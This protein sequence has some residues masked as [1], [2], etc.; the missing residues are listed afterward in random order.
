MSISQWRRRRLWRG[1]LLGLLL[2][3]ASAEAADINE[4]RRLYEEQCTQ[5]HG[6]DGR[7]ELPG[8]P[9]FQ[10]GDALMQPDAALFAVI[11]QGQGGMPAF[12]GMLNEREILDVI[13]FLRTFMGFY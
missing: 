4:G 7:G 11:S 13:A 8:M 10:Q 2:A 6:P 9:N 1:A 3:A 5:C 12:E